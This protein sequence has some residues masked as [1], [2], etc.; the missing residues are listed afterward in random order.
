MSCSA[1]LLYKSYDNHIRCYEKIDIANKYQY[2]MLKKPSI[3]SVISD[4]HD[5]SAKV[6]VCS[7]YSTV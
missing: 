3:L 4:N 2:C 7:L 1:L 6:V 5:H